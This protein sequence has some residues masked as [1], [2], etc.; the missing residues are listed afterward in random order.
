MAECIDDEN[1]AD[2]PPD[3]V[4]KS[5]TN[6]A[7]FEVSFWLL[8]FKME[9]QGRVTDITQGFKTFTFPE[10]SLTVNV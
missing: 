10:K 7:E 4:A 3:I 8:Y 1:L 5:V 9:S 6:D 2:R